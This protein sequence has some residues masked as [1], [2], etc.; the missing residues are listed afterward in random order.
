MQTLQNTSKWYQN[1]WAALMFFTRLPFWR[2]YQPPKDS[3]RAVVEYWSMAGWITGGLC[4]LSFVVFSYIFP[5]YIAVI[6]A[7]C[8]RVL[9]TGG[10]HEDGLSD[11]F[12]GFGGGRDR[13]RILDIMKDSS[14]GSYALIG[15]V[16]YYALL[17]TTLSSI[18]NTEL[19]FFII[20]AADP[21]S[22]MLSSIQTQLLPYA[23]T[24]E[25]SKAHNI[26]R[27]MSILPEIIS[28]VAGLLPLAL[29]YFEFFRCYQVFWAFIAI[30]CVVCG[31]L[32]WLLKLKIGGYT[33]D[34]CGALFLLVELSFYLSM[35]VFV[36]SIGFC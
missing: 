30:P 2:I 29:L 32:M 21:F 36:R 35:L 3:F 15:M 23:R 13:Q 4:A 25:Q 22:K 10:L 1:A 5:V 28:A 27:K 16:L 9:L 33:G 31:A 7:F 24:E 11:F 26:Y 34:C 6:L 14:T 18:K 8:I 20:L 12:D 19:I 17:F